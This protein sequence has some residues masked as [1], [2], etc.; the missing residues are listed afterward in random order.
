ML[1]STQLDTNLTQVHID[2]HAFFKMEN[3]DQMRPF[4]MNIV[5]SSDLWMFV[6]SNGGLTAGRKNADFSLFPYYTDD[7]ITEMSHIT[8][9]KT[10]FQVGEKESIHI[11]EPFTDHFDHGQKISRNLYKSVHGDQ[12]RFEEVNHDLGLR[13]WYQWSFSNQFGLVRRAEVQ[14]LT[15]NSVNIR[16]LDGLQNILPAGVGAD[17]QNASSNLVDA[18]KRSEL[19][20][21][22]SLG[23]FA[24]SSIISDK[25]EPNEALYANIAYV[26][27]IDPEQILLCPNQIDAFR[28][29]KSTYHETDIKGEKAAYLVLKQLVL[30]AHAK[31]QWSLVADTYQSQSQ[32]IDRIGLL[33]DH[34][35]HASDIEQDIEAGKIQLIQMVAAADGLQLTADS[36][37]D[38]R[39][40]SNTLFNIL[41]GGIFDQGYRIPKSDFLRYISKANF[42]LSQQ[43]KKKLEELPDS[44]DVS[45]LRTLAETH[46]DADFKRLALEYLPLRFSRRHGD[47]SRPWNKFSINT[48][49]PQTGEK[50]LDYEGNWR[51][52]FQNWEALAWAYPEFLEG[53]IYKFLNASTFDGYN[54]YRVTKSGFDWEVIEHDNPWSYIG[55]WGDHQIIYLLKFL[56]FFQ[57][58]HPKGLQHFQ[59]QDIYVYAHVPYEIKPYHQILRDPKNTILFNEKKDHILR[60]KMQAEGADGALLVNKSGKRIHVCFVEK[61]LATTLAKVANFIPEGG[62]WM[63]TQRPDW[64][65]ANNALVGNGISMV[66]LYYLRRFV[67]FFVDHKEVLQNQ[68]SVSIELSQFFQ[69]MLDILT[70]HADKIAS[71]FSD[72]DRKVLTDALGQA[73]SDYRIP[74]YESG[75]SGEKVAIDPKKITEFFELMHQYLDQTIRANKRADGLYHAYNLIHLEDSGYRISRLSEMLEGQVAALSSG[76]LTP[77]DACQILTQ[78]RNSKLY[79]QDQ[80]S[81]LLYPNTNLAGFLGKNILTADQ[82]KTSKLL[83]K[84]QSDLHQGVI[85]KNSLGQF[86]F[87]PSF[88]NVSDLKTAL[89]QLANT[90]YAE[91]VTQDYELVVNLYEETFQHK[92]FTGR[93]GTF[94]AYEGLGSIY[95]HMVSKLHLAVAEIIGDLGDQM[96]AIDRDQLFA[97]FFEIGEG[98]G[99]HKHPKIYG[100]FP[101]DPYSHTPLHKGA[102]QPGMTGQVKED[103]LVKLLEY[104]VSMDKGAIQFKPVCIRRS[105]FLHHDA[106]FE[107]YAQDGTLRKMLVPSGSLVFTL[108]QVPIQYRIAQ[109][110]E[111]IVHFNDGTQE[112]LEDHSLGQKITQKLYA[113][114]G[115][116][117]K[118]EV[119]VEEGLLIN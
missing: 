102:Q 5:S 94:F 77:Q 92:S 44:F 93:S 105:I 52:I 108:A 83:W 43:V 62:I 14:N 70:L 88:K 35:K 17:L 69:K 111:I 2:G 9:C 42:V 15:P 71:G 90:C 98:I 46:D 76:A 95:W 61:I 110:A 104:G 25:A 33:D 65:D 78:M 67:A 81:Y 73:A 97:H 63:N 34:I 75:F 3:H 10:I 99:V 60:Q 38:S 84:L 39:H 31:Q 19:S 68:P 117:E 13:F 20:D 37:S 11:W 87:H 36:L 6:S 1:E 53:M 40:Y 100:A 107:Y 23:I 82:I 45:A 55:Y 28:K 4:F 116:I 106:P 112:K 85:Q 109:K 80:K 29:L 54:P 96:S 24:L 64:N 50:I 27:G 119:Q 115:A 26:V 72:H 48:V 21:R 91:L 101:T 56:E 12:I 47:P 59:E 74:I 41:R 32:V 18:Y 16:L 118:I 57:S 51:D 49:D 30:G 58:Y 86:H 66:N 114:T 22:N 103:L 8:G 7:K 113:R 89:N 79:R